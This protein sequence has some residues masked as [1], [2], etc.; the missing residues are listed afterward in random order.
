MREKYELLANFTC[1]FTVAISHEL[2]LERTQFVRSSALPARGAKTDRLLSIL[3]HLGAKH[4][5]SGPSAAAYME[6]EKFAAAGITVE[7]MSYEYPEYLQ[8][9]GGFEPKVSV[10]DLLLMVGPEAPRYI[11]GKCS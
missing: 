3:T 9:H 6:L 7:Y 10:L 2:G 4:Y 1:D 5:V 8:L 11:W